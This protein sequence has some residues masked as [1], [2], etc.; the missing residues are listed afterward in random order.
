MECSFFLRDVHDKMANGK[1]ASEKILEEIRRTVNS[2]RYIGWVNPNYR[3]RQGRSPSVWKVNVERNLLTGIF[4]G[5]V[6]R[7]GDER[8]GDLLVEDYEDLHDSE[9]A[10]NYGKRFKSQDTFESCKNHSNFFVR[11]KH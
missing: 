1:T 3:E 4:L 8:S 7:V 5:S 9:A 6:S 2:L 11:M 10:E